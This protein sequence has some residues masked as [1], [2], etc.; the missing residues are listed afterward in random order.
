M[1]SLLTR[2]VIESSGDVFGRVAVGCVADH[3]AGFA[4]RSVA[5]QDALQQPL[6]RLPRRGGL[7]FVRGYWRGHG[8]SVIHIDLKWY[9]ISQHFTALSLTGRRR[10]HHENRFPLQHK[11]SKNCYDRKRSL[12]VKRNLQSCSLPNPLEQ[13]SITTSARDSAVHDAEEGLKLYI[14]RLIWL[15][16][17]TS[18]ILNI[19][20]SED[21]TNR[22]HFGGQR[23][24]FLKT[25]YRSIEHKLLLVHSFSELHVKLTCIDIYLFYTSVSTVS[26]YWNN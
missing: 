24:S 19:P 10:T 5:E 7:G 15:I 11:F 6:L 2:E 17:P 18:Y 23:V 26:L 21:S 16:P 3:Q 8:P 14:F 9:S 20:T 12:C 22:T 1:F 13:I 4:H 25:L